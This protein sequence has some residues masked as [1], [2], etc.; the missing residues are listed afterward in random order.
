MLNIL[1]LKVDL[2]YSRSGFMQRQ[3]QN[4]INC[5]CLMNRLINYIQSNDV[6]STLQ[7]ILH[8]YQG[9]NLSDI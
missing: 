3:V 4:W 6:H 9:V 7:Q 1:G 8:N 2:S 5:I